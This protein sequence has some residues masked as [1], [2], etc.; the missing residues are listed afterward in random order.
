MHRHLSRF[1]FCSGVAGLR[2]AY[3][4]LFVDRHT[5]KVVCPRLGPIS[6]F[7]K[8][9]FRSSFCIHMKTKF[10]RRDCLFALPV[11]KKEVIRQKT[12]FYSSF[13]RARRFS[14]VAFSPCLSR[15]RPSRCSKLEFWT[16]N[17]FLILFFLQI[18]KSQNTNNYKLL[19]RKMEKGNAGTNFKK[20]T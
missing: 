14:A 17:R 9:A 11:N 7:G 6:L 1:F 12:R 10:E 16:F 18:Q 19:V 15:E 4:A 2:W 5:G 3:R 20:K 8:Y 13:A